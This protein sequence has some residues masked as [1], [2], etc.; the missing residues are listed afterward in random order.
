MEFTKLIPYLGIDKVALFGLS[1]YI[2]CIVVVMYIF[3]A[4]S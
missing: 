3:M 1:M 4:S 2:C